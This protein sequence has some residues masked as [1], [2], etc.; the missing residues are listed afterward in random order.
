MGFNV[1]FSDVDTVWLRDPIPFFRHDVD[2][3]FQSDTFSVEFGIDDVPNTGFYWLKSTPQTINLLKDVETL[4][5]QRG[6]LDDQS[7]WHDTLREWRN[8]R[9]A[10]N[11]PLSESNVDEYLKRIGRANERSTFLT[12]RQLHRVEFPSGNAFFFGRHTYETAQRE[13]KKEVVVA[14]INYVIG[15][16]KKKSNL[17]DRGFWYV[18]GD[19]LA[20]ANSHKPHNELTSVDENKQVRCKA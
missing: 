1:F 2:L 18:G 8:K 14:H 20:D 5:A 7:N 16:D 15:H 17:I 10:I 12:F 11:I 6:H 3:E 13:T 9:R 19:P 4:C